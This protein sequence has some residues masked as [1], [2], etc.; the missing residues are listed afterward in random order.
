M[1]AHDAQPHYSPA[2]VGALM[3]PALLRRAM[4]DANGGH[5]PE[6]NSSLALRL[7]WRLAIHA[8]AAVF[9]RH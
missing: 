3:D 4:I 5:Q 1:H 8:V 9:W 7:R 6:S 2:S